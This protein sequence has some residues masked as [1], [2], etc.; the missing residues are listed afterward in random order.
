MSR[1]RAPDPDD[2]TT[3]IPAIRD[4]APELS[5]A[6]SDATTVLPII[7]PSDVTMQLPRLPS[8][9]PGTARPIPQVVKGRATATDETGLLGIILPAPPPSEKV[10]EP[11]RD[12]WSG[13]PLPPPVKAI[14][15]GDGYRSIHSEYTRTTVGSVIRGTLRG[16]GEL[17]ITFGLVVL[18][19][20][21]YEVWGKTAI[22]DAH[23]NELA[24][25]LDQMWGPD[26]TVSQS[27]GA[28]PSGG[29]SPTA[30]PNLANVIAKL[31]IPKL[32]KQW[33]VVQ[34][35]SQQDIRYAP[36]HYPKSANAGQQ[37][38][39]SVAGHRNRATFWDLD[40]LKTGDKI[41]VENKTHFYVYQ[42][43]ASK[44]VLPT[45]VEVVQPVPPGQKA[46]KLLTLT[47]CNPKFDNYQRLIVHGSLVSEMPRSEGK[48]AELGG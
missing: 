26:P 2:A 36:G 16:T 28:V 17:M 30:G 14:K 48:P 22:V 21:A 39:F 7:I 29:P 46:G 24:Q 43:T 13:E 19:F 18:L 27:A 44:V 3:I 32:N 5:Q 33:V 45:Q 25:Q 47:T 20:A 10:P 15:D 38:N 4:A 41:I 23:Q 11:E 6:P 8:P 12:K 37:G 34:G 31:Y 40:Q 35:V 42:V 1:H 9:H